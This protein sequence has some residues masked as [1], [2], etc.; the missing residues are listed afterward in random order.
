MSDIRQARKALIKRI[1]EDERIRVV[2]KSDAPMQRENRN[3]DTGACRDLH[4]ADFRR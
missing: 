4:A 1:L 3:V 2:P